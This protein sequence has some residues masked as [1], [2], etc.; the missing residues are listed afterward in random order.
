MIR[1]LCCAVILALSTPAFAQDVLERYLAK[2]EPVYGWQEVEHDDLFLADVYDIRLASL[3]WQDNVWTH[4]M[5]VT[6]PKILAPGGT[7]LLF[8]WGGENIDG[9]PVYEEDPLFT[10]A[11]TLIATQSQAIVIELY[12]IPNQP[13]Y[14]RVED[15]LLAYTF[16]QYIDTGDEEWPIILPMAKCVIQAMTAVQEF[17]QQRLERSVRDF[18]IAGASKRGW[19]SWM[20]GA[21]GDDRVL[22]I[23]PIVYDTLNIATQLDYQLEV[24][25]DFSTYIRDYVLLGLPELRTTPQGQELLSIVDPYSYRDRITM[26][27]YLLIGTNDPYW[28][29]DAL[30]HYGEDLEGPTTMRFFPNA[31]HD[32]GDEITDAIQAVADF[33]TTQVRGEIWP[34]LDWELTR[35]SLDPNAPTPKITV[36]FDDLPKSI[37]AWVADSDDRDFR[38]AEWESYSVDTA[39]TVTVAEFPRDT[40]Y[41]AL[42]LDVNYDGP[43]LTDIVLSTPVLVIENLETNVHSWEL[44]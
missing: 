36:R 19:T 22:A 31:P 28:P 4:H 8:V 29:V 35:E 32:L 5:R 37:K 44:Y 10:A 23:A 18:V 3:T 12:Q 39:S 24:W 15:D 38:D 42:Y 21:T 9:E 27:K 34:E 14:D 2:P 1:L 16:Q 26:P 6:V 7:A 13:L 33:F 11:A 41:R 40:R 43:L 20:A 17:A 30:R 25:G